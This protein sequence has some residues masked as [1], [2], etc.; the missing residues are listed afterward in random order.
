[1]PTSAATSVGGVC[2]T[3]AM[4]Q[5][6]LAGCKCCLSSRSALKRVTTTMTRNAQQRRDRSFQAR[7]R[8]ASGAIC[9]SLEIG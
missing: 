1:M 5:Q 2:Q 7:A 6:A 4:Y 9:V 8:A 3:G